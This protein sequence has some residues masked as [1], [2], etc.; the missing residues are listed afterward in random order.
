MCPA[1]RRARR[2]RRTAL[3]KY[4]SGGGRRRCGRRGRQPRH[5]RARVLPEYRSGGG[6]RRCGRRGRQPPHARA[7]VL[8]ETVRG[9]R[10]R[11][12]SPN[13]EARRKAK[14]RSARAPTATREG[15][16]APR[17]SSRRART[18]A[19]PKY[20]SGGG[21]R[22]C[23]RRGRQPPHARARV[24]PETVRGGRG[25]RRSPNIE[26]AEESEDAVGEGANRHT[27]GRVCSPKQ[28]AAGADAGA[29]PRIA[30][31]SQNSMVAILGTTWRGFSTNRNGK[32]RR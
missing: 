11:R 12:R 17:N 25:R 5:A 27:R 30:N 23:G 18:P 24:L 15:A 9:G 4:R 22:R 3:P 7:R 13:I 6:K 28:F 32:G 29:P 8:P 26:A 14:M 10:G 2:A 21:K 19:L 16:C 31:V 20:R 1:R